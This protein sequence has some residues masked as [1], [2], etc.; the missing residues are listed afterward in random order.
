MEI[1]RIELEELDLNTTQFSYLL[2]AV[3][4]EEPA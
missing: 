1:S 2:S 4:Q 3:N